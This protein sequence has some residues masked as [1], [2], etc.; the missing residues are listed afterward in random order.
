MIPNRRTAVAALALAGA[1]PVLIRPALAQQG[2]AEYAAT[3][4]REGAK[5][6]R[7]SELAR[8]RTQTQE[9]QAFALLEVAEQEAIASVLAAAL[10]A[11]GAAAPEMDAPAMAEVEELAAMQGAGFDQTYVRAQRAG[12]LAA[13]QLT[14]PMAAMREMTVPVVTAKLAEAAIQSHLAMLERIALDV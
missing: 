7:M 14:Q 12:H 13:L 3:M 10:E 2:A 11:E 1:A 9:V 8:E 6:K 4:L 5:L